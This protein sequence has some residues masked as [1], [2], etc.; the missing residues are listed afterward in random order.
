MKKT[1]TDPTAAAY[2][3]AGKKSAGSSFEDDYDSAGE[4]TGQG[5]G[6]DDG[7]ESQSGSEQDLTIPGADVQKMEQLKQNGDMAGLG[8][9]VAQFLN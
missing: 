5:A 2:D 6:D 1:T 9:Y 8:T 3:S 4:S 7:D